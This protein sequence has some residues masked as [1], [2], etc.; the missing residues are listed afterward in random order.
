MSVER[1]H[2]WGGIGSLPKDGIV[3]S[4]DAELRAL[5]VEARRAGVDPPPVGLLGG[6]LCRT[7][8]G[9]GDPVH[10]EGTGATRVTVLRPSGGRLLVAGTDLDCRDSRTPWPLESRSP[11]PSG[12][13]PPG[14]LR[15]GYGFR[16]S[17]GR[18]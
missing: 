8:G 3:V 6:D 11:G 5:V 10:L 14:R 17:D 4:S 18:S 15:C 2:D 7:L 13:W 12:R 9:R 16:R 1:G